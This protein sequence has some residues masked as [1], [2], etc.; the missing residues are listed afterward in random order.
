[1]DGIWV[2]HSFILPLAQMLHVLFVLCAYELNDVRIGNQIQCCLVC[3]RP[4]VILR[5]FIAD[6]E[7]DMPEIPAMETLGDQ[8]RV[9]A[10]MPGIIQPALFSIMV[11]MAIV[12][13]LM[14]SPV[15][16]LVYRRKPNT[17]TDADAAPANA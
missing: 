17:V 8:H 13:T 14:A 9:A 16:E 7:F 10:W 5:I 2:N 15:F 1:M 12:T 11:I 4:G 3:K 6:F